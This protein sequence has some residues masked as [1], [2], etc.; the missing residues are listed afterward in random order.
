MTTITKFRTI[1]RRILKLYRAANSIKGENNVVIKNLYRP[2]GIGGNKIE[3]KSPNRNKISKI[4]LTKIFCKFFI[5]NNQL[6]D[7]NFTL[8]NFSH[9]AT[10]NSLHLS[11]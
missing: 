11:L 6:I 1:I 7:R 8:Y 5:K 2:S 9:F 10:L 3:D 4:S